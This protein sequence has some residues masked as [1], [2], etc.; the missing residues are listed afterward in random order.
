MVRICL[1]ILRLQI[2]VIPGIVTWKVQVSHIVLAQW[3]VSMW[4]YQVISLSDMEDFSFFHQPLKLPG[5]M[6]VL[7]TEGIHKVG[8]IGMNKFLG[9][10]RGSLSD[11]HW[12]IREQHTGCFSSVILTR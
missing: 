5:L 7:V 3:E 10:K 6:S 4:F 1:G 8:W 2:K 9:K 11:N 12:V